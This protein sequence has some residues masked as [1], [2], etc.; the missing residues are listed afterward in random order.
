MDRAKSIKQIGFKG[1]DDTIIIGVDISNKDRSTIVIGRNIGGSEYE[2][3]NQLW[4]EEAEEVYY[5]LIGV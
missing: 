2:I 4:D 3:I 5:T 1:V